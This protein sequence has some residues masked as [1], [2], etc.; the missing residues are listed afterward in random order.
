MLIE[1]T[2]ERPRTVW[3]DI[4][5]PP[6]VQYLLPFRAAFEAAGL[7]TVIT[8]RDHDSTLRMLEDAGVCVNAFGAVAGRAK[9]RKVTATVRR[10]RE[11]GKFFGRVGRPD[12][13]LGSSRSAVIAAWRL[14]IPSF[15]I[16]DYEHVFLRLYRFTGSTI[17]FPDVIDPRQYRD[18][19]LRPEQLIP[20]TGMKEDLTFAGVDLDAVQPLD[21]GR[22]PAGV[23]RVLCRAPSETSH[24]Y[25][26]ASKTMLQA[27]L[28]HLARADAQ[29]VFSPR[30]RRQAAMLDSLDWKYQPIVLQR[31]VPFVSLFKSLDAVV[32]SGGT[33]L[34]EAAYL[35]IPA[36]SIFQNPT[37]AVDRW[38]ERL[39]RAKLLGSPKDLD[40]I[41]LRPRGPLNRLDS[42]P[43]LLGEIVELVAAAA[44]KSRPEPAYVG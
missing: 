6:Q 27:T 44:G 41:E 20:V 33:M 34:R 39:G 23:V 25:R 17:L 24:Y 1:T 7:R 38:L 4:E 30:E 42:N 3:I 21:L 2:H 37:G 18:Q 22:L 10:V 14:G 35:G 31:P 29:I 19:G 13:Q 5:N 26:E 43:E 8:S 16:N 11:L 12:A 32:C 15:V 9:H 36:Y 28:E 40:Q